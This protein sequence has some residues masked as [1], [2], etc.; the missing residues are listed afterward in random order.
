MAL[1]ARR[2]ASQVRE[3]RA[4]RRR[5]RQQVEAMERKLAQKVAAVERNNQ[6]RRRKEKMETFKSPA[7]EQGEGKCQNCTK[8]EDAVNSTSTSTSLSSAASSSLQTRLSAVERRCA[9][10]EWRLSRLGARMELSRGRNESVWRQLEALRHRADKQTRLLSGALAAVE[11]IKQGA[12]ASAGS[13]ATHAGAKGVASASEV[14]SLHEEVRGLAQAVE[15]VGREHTAL[16][17]K[18]LESQINRDHLRH[19][20]Q[21]VQHIR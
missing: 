13:G 4:N 5:M 3:M 2:A 21:A 15:E 18:A 8:E 17:K 6:E 16:K 7:K 14:E 1:A 19:M 20:Q 12:A 9:E 10:S 11:A